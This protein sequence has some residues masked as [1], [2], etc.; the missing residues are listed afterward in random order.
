MPQAHLLV[1]GDRG[2][3]KRSFIKQLNKPFLKQGHNKFDEYGSD[4]ANFDAS[5]VYIRD[6]SEAHDNVQTDDL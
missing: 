2:C 1:L 6:I 3:G 5:Y 4:Y